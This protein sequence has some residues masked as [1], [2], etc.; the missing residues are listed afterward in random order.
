MVFE[1]GNEVEIAA[2]EEQ[3]MNVVNVTKGRSWVYDYAEKIG[4]QENTK[5]YCRF[6][7]KSGKKCTYKVESKKGQTTNI[8]MHLKEKHGLKPPPKQKQASMDSFMSV[9]SKPKNKTFREAFAEM[10]AKQYLPLP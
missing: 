6:E 3:T 1:A 2:I 7:L 5:F 4:T 10:V 9:D 8:A